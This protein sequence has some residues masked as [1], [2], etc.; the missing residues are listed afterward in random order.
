MVGS[1]VW[2]PEPADSVGKRD[3][4]ELAS[5]VARFGGMTLEIRST[6]FA[7]TW[8]SHGGKRRDEVRNRP[9]IFTQR[10]S[11][12]EPGCVSPRILLGLSTQY[13]LESTFCR[14]GPPSDSSWI[15]YLLLTHDYSLP[16]RPGPF[17][18]KPTPTLVTFERDANI[19]VETQFNRSS[20]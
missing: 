12:G 15:F 4:S 20:Q 16:L 13:S 1:H 11:P 3:P 18:S 9:K 5:E 7:P 17:P 8:A 10:A 14:F 6:K 2:S 19:E